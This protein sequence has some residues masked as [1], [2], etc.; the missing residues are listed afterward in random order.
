MKYR[1]ASGKFNFF[2]N[3]I[4]DRVDRFFSSV[5]DFIS[6]KCSQINDRARLRAK[7]SRDVK[8]RAHANVNAEG[9]LWDVAGNRIKESASTIIWSAISRCSLVLL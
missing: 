9:L 5:K 2:Q 7:P 3:V 8:A 1:F 6:F 4:R